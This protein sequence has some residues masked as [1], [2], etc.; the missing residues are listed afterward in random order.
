MDATLP[1]LHLF[2]RELGAMR[3]DLK[4]LMIAW[5]V[6]RSDEGLGYVC[7]F[8]LSSSVVQEY[9]SG[10]RHANENVEIGCCQDRG[11]AFVKYPTTTDLCYYAEP[12]GSA[13]SAISIR[14]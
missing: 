8:A 9:G 12:N 4:E 2:H 1:S 7:I 10:E 6:A 13:L 3:Q 11:N 5:T 14:R